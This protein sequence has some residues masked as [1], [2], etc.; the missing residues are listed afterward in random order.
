MTAPANVERVVRMPAD[1]HETIKAKAAE[2][3]L[4]MAEYIRR[5]LWAWIADGSP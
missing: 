5:A 1:L 2:N 4:S 3:G